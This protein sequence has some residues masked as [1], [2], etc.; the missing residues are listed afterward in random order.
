VAVRL[1]QHNA[2]RDNTVIDVERLIERVRQ[3]VRNLR[4]ATARRQPRR[5]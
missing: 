3:E 2:K 1:L 4:A 5:R